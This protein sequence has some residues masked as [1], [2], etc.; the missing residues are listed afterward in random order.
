MINYS[1]FS[2]ILTIIIYDYKCFF[3]KLIKLFL[4]INMLK[5]ICPTI[6]NFATTTLKQYYVSFIKFELINLKSLIL[7]YKY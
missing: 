1:L 2:F 3:L 5:I 7:L 6:L 4:N